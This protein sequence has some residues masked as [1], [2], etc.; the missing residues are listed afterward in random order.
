MNIIYHKK[1]AQA[2]L[3][4]DSIS[5]TY[6]FCVEITDVNSHAKK[7]ITEI[8]DTSWISKLEPVAKSAYEYTALETIKRLVVIFESVDNK[9]KKDFGEFMISMSSGFC[10]REKHNHAILPLSELWKPKLS[11]NEGFDFHTLSPSNKFS[12]GEAKF[13]SSGNSYGSAAEQAYRFSKENKDKRDGVHLRYFCS[14]IAIKNLEKNKRGFIVAFSINS[15]K[16]E[17]ILKKTLQNEDI[18]KLS[19]CCDELYI[20]GVKS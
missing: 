2:D 12:F 7:L 5:E 19:K 8:S 18:K 20:I 15:K 4:E 1:V 11:G 13:V 17:S 6:L 14:P 10:L 9:I 3:P 16:P